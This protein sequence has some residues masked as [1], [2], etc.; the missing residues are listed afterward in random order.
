M[1]TANSWAEEK[2]GLGFPGLVS[3]ENHEE[4]VVHEG[5]GEAAMG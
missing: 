5:E 3:K 2:V 4:K 1:W